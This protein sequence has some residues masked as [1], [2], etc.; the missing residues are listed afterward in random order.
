MCQEGRL[1]LNDHKEK[2]YNFTIHRQEA[3]MTFQPNWQKMNIASFIYAASWVERTDFYLWDSIA[4][5]TA[6][7]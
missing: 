4:L 1:G 2:D 7:Q 6:Y 5:Y 3:E